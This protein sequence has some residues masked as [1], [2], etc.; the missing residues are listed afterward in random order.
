MLPNVGGINWGR[1]F[2][3]G[4]L[5]AVLLAL[6]TVIMSSLSRL[7][8]AATTRTLT[9]MRLALSNLGNVA[10][11]YLLRGEDPQ[12]ALTFRFSFNGH[13]L[14]RPPVERVMPGDGAVAGAGRRAGV[15]L[16]GMNL[17]AGAGGVS[18]KSVGEIG[19][20]LSEASG[21]I[22]IV[23][24]VLMTVTYLLPRPLARPLRQVTMGLRRTQMVTRRVE[25]V[26]KQVGKLDDQMARGGDAAERRVNWRWNRPRQA[27]RHSKRNNRRNNKLPPQAHRAARAQRFRQRQEPRR[28]AQG[29]LRIGSLT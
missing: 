6:L 18:M 26:R 25:R 16:P 8:T 13:A 5:L 20:K 14:G 12:G 19:D 27:N 28:Q 9:P 17:P 24:S 11:A 15:G 1:W 3:I 10:T 23:S 4:G 22:K 7:R 29:G 2:G 21:M